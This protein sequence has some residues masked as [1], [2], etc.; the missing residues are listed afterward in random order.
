MD[1]GIAVMTV[2]D[3]VEARELW[4]TLDGLG[5]RA[6]DD[7]VER[8]AVFLRRNPATC[9]AAREN[10]EMIGVILCGHDGRRARI[11]H[12]AVRKNHMGRGVGTALV[13]AVVE[14]L[15]AEG[16]FKASLVAFAGNDAG[17]AFWEKRGFAAR[18]DLVYRDRVITPEEDLPQTLPA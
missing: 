14:S 2:A 17:N 16:V 10:G 13:A 18:G 6:Y 4:R 1:F 15:K 5:L 7:S 9:F 3:C 11:Y 8:L 12:A